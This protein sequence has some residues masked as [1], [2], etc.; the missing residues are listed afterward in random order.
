MMIS[1]WG[2]EGIESSLNYIITILSTAITKL[3]KIITK[4][5]NNQVVAL[6][7]TGGSKEVELLEHQFLL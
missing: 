5:L 4:R 6:I 1:H 2:N 7:E 3:L